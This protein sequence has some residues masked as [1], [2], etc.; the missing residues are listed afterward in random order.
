VEGAPNLRE[1]LAPVPS[2][3][4]H[5]TP[6]TTTSG[7]ALPRPGWPAKHDLDYVK[8]LIELALLLLAVPWIL[9]RL[10]SNPGGT[11]RK[12]GESKLT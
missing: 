4:A 3:P 2:A 11:A 12:A 6:T 5:A 8:T 9:K 1:L 10:A 7:A